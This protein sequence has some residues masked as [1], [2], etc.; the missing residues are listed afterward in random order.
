MFNSFNVKAVEH[1][2][3]KTFGPTDSLYKEGQ[4]PPMGVG[5]KERE[6]FLCSRE[7]L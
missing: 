4:A 2:K 5:H 3:A 1:L 6:T 7:S